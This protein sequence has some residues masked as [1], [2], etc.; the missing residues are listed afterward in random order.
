MNMVLNSVSRRQALVVPVA[1]DPEGTVFRFRLSDLGWDNRVWDRVT[2]FY[3]YC[4]RSDRQQ[5]RDLYNKLNTESP[6]VRGDWFVDT[7]MQPPLYYDVLQLRD[8][9]DQIAR[10]DLGV[11]I[12][13]DISR[14]AIQRVAFR[15]SGVS[16][17]NRM[18]E[19]H[20]ARQGGYFWVSYDFDKDVDEADLRRNPLGPLNR[21]DHNFQHSFQNLAGEMIWSLPNGMQA[22]LLADANG[23]RLD[24]AVQTVVK[25]QRRPDGS[26]QNGISCIGCHGVTGMNYPRTFTE[27]PDYANTHQRDFDRR[28]LDEIRRIYPGNIQAVI[29]GDAGRYLG[30]LRTLVGDLLPGPGVIEYDDFINLY[31]QYE[32][33][34]GFRQGALEL[35]ADATTVNR[36]VRNKANNEGLLPLI[37]S[38]PL[39]ARDDWSC[40]FRQIIRDV[41]RVN[42]CQNTFDAPELN[43]FCD[44]R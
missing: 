6:F 9:I 4:L 14:S 33:R 35:Q 29:Q 26:V 18:F 38:D 23:N 3:P 37:L 39:V 15:G 32:A 7:V 31:G 17:H 1:V 11:D 34:V 25:D 5:H 43:N 2:S 40:R 19:R 30:K 12:N 27:I 22:F 36:E 20:R 16:Q 13:N 10:D 44:N 21:D 41:R 8:T 24:K 42:F 28:E